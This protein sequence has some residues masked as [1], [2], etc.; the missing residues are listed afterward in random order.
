[1]FSG[2]VSL[3]TCVLA[4]MGIAWTVYRTHYDGPKF[5]EVFYQVKIEPPVITVLVLHYSFYLSSALAVAALASVIITWRY[6]D[7]RS[8]LWVNVGCFFLAA[9]CL[10][11]VQAALFQPMISLL[12]GISGHRR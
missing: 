7:K 4:V 11:I 9:T 1:M 12:E 8:T 5:E 10:A 3:S 6:G 2:T